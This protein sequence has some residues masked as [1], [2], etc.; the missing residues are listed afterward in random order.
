MGPVL[1]PPSRLATLARGQIAQEPDRLRVVLRY[2]DRE[3]YA[4]TGIATDSA[5]HAKSERMANCWQNPAADY[6]SGA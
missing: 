1:Q 2:R 5:R 3:T 6:S 4:N